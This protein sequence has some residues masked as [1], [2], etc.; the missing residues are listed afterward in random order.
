MPF[1]RLTTRILNIGGAVSCGI[2]SLLALIAISNGKHA[3]QLRG[4]YSLENLTGKISRK[5]C[6][7]IP[8]P[9][10]QFCGDPSVS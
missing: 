2:G 1:A 4:A 5:L 8:R 9:M 3:R 6:A 7:Q 10:R